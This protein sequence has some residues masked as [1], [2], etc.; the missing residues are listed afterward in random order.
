M[1]WR[2]VVSVSAMS[3]IELQA[4]TSDLKIVLPISLHLLILL[5]KA[6]SIDM[7]TFLG[8]YYH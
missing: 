5:L 8:E 2:L 1:E 4:A 7:D 3:V 6:Q